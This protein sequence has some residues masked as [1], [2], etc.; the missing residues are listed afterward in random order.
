MRKKVGMAVC[1]VLIVLFAALSFWPQPVVSDAAQYEIQ[2]VTYYEDGQPE[3]ITDR[4]DLVQLKALLAGAQCSRMAQT[5]GSYSLDE[6][7]FEIDGVCAGQ[8]LHIILGDFNEVYVSA[9][10][11]DFEI[12]DGAALLAQVKAL[13]GVEE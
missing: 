7:A 8:P 3:E 11:G 13:A 5:R 4:V 6:V 9:D 10:E 1:A 2:R 12:R